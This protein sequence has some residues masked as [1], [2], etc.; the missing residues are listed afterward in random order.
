MRIKK[1]KNIALYFC[2]LMIVA[3]V[4]SFAQDWGAMKGYHYLMRIAHT[5]NILS[6]FSQALK[7]IFKTHGVRGFTAFVRSTLQ[8]PW[9]DWSRVQ[10]LMQR[11]FQ[12]KLQ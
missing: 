5:F 6:R 10:E 7:D 3:P 8:S 2:V 11:P 12:L 4:F 9:L 1:K